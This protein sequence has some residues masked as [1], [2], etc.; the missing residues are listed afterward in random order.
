MRVERWAEER[1]AGAAGDR[2]RATTALALALPPP[3]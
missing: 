3:S 2:D 1:A